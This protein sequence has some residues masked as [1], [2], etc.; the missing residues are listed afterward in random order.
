MEKTFSRLGWHKHLDCRAGG[1]RCTWN[2]RTRVGSSVIVSLEVASIMRAA[3]WFDDLYSNP[4]MREYCSLALA[5]NDFSCICNHTT[6]ISV[7]S[8]A[9]HEGL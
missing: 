5:I 1:P 7:R 9:L 8:D 6:V 4:E 2:G 3:D